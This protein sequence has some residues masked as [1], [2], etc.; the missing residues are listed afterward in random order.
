[1][2]KFILLLFSCAALS[3]FAQVTTT[4]AIIDKGYSGEV[5]ITYDPTAGN[6]G[7][8]S[9]TKCYAHTGLITSAS[10][11]NGDW[12]NVIGSWRGATQP[13][14]TKVGTKWQLTI[15]NIYTFYGVPET[16]DII[17]LAFVF[18]DGPG[19][20][21]EGKTT[22]GGDILLFLGEDNTGSDIWAGF[23]P[24]AA[25][26]QSRPTGIEQGI[27]YDPNDPTAVT[28]C[29]Y[30]ASKTAPAQHVFLIGDM[31]DWKLDNSYQLKR[32][33]NYFWIRVTGLT[34]GEPYRF[35]YAVVRADGVKKQISDLYS[36]M[37]LHPDDKYEPRSVNPDLLG[38]PLKGAD[39]GYVTVIQTDKPKFQWSNET[40][41]FQRPDKNNL[42]IYELWVYDH[43]PMRSLQGLMER[44]DYIQNLGVNA[45]E[46]MPVNEFDGNVN[47][48]Y[49]PNHYFAVDRAYGSGDDLKT[50]VDE[51]HKRGLAVILDMVFNH[52]T[53][54]NPMNK[55]YPY[56]SD[57][58]QNPW[59]NVS[60]PHPDNVYED[61]NH[62][63]EPA[64]KMFIRVLKYWIEEYHIDG[65]RM[66]LSHGLCG[67][68]YNAVANLKDYYQNGV[69]AAA[70]DAYFILEH[71]GTSMGTDRPQLVNAGMLCWQ[72]TCNAYQQTAMGWLKDGDSFSDANKDG[73]VSYCN[74]HDEERPF[75]KAK[76]WG[77]GDLQTNDSARVARVPLNMAFLCL[78]N[79]S[80]LFYHFDEL[81]FDFSKYQ[82][83][84]GK[85]GKDGVDAYGKTVAANAKTSEA[86]MTVKYRPESWMRE[87]GIRMQAYARTAE[88]L[89]L[90]TRLMPQ[91]FEGNPTSVSVGSGKELRT[92]QWGNDVFVAGNFSVAASQSV[93]LPDGTWYD[94]LAGGVQAGASYTLQPGEVI[95]FTGTAIT[96]PVIP[97]AYP[98]ITLGLDETPV[99]DFFSNRAD[100]AVKRIIDGRLVLILDGRSYDALGRRI[101]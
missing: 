39:G 88:I 38:Y 57:L 53:G 6:G 95:V 26:Q 21:K 3:L 13:Q 10:A 74:N 47:W 30:A 55:L 101:Q 67:A 46:L 37:V 90:R 11:D 40:L 33:G 61:W 93:T 25:T 96:P 9:A 29:T 32:D 65:Y 20:T 7:M 62:D 66:D 91:V 12:K 48:G 94:Y 73:Y 81:G 17:A 1:M 50:F 28:L 59:F 64:H 49:S 92:I 35:Q 44:L 84:N 41:N 99:Y 43:T 83:A 24:A 56:G 34:P 45:V 42:L 22:A 97:N 27:Y 75:F 77:N 72:N 31:N 8:A 36:E 52:A 80:H 18:H 87:A 100:K 71:W 98:D 15:P 70:N 78:L 4:P 79:G 76:Q 23:T 68:S 5:I 69:Q 82:F 86:K 2:K 89:Q 58:A 85:W 63:F 51:C 14:L 60:A 19:G 16:T 54:L